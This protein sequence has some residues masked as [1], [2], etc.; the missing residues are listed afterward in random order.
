[1]DLLLKCFQK[2]LLSRND[3]QLW[4]ITESS[5]DQY[6]SLAKRLGIWSSICLVHVNFEDL[7]R[8][9]ASADIVLNPR[10]N[11]DGYPVKL[12][13]YLASGKPIVSFEGSAKIIDHGINGWIVDDGDI[14][15]FA[16]AILLL[17]DRPDLAQTL[18]T[19]A[20]KHACKMFTWEAIA[21][22]LEVIYESVIKSY[23]DN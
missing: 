14:N 13:N 2:A 4:I 20:K 7:P 1:M 10:I 17:L 22:N 23:H 3:L 21:K 15:A 9:L 8:H 12:L 6:R 19:N 16:D 18:G 5:F 11:C